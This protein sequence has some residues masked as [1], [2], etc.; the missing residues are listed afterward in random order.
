MP[1]Y[2]H[3]IHQFILRKYGDY[4]KPKWEEF[5]PEGSEEYDKSIKKTKKASVNIIS[6]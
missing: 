1:W 2:Q 5:V 6:L 4:E 3:S